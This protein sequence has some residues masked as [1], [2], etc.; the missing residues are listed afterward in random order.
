MCHVYKDNQLKTALLYQTFNKKTLF[1][2]NYMNQTSQQFFV[3]F[4]IY[5]QTQIYLRNTNYQSTFAY[6]Y[7]NCKTNGRLLQYNY[8]F[9]KQ[10]K[11]TGYRK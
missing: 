8:C 3:H 4:K 5:R 1:N 10:S 11:Y 6:I 9:R 7:I 2:T